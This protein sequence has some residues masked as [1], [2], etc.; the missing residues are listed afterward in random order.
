[1]NDLFTYLP[2]LS[3]SKNDNNKLKVYKKILLS[4]DEILELEADNHQSLPKDP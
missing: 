4:V 3:N 1:M 2:T